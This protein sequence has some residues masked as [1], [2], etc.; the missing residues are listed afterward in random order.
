[1]KRSKLVR[2]RIV[3]RIKKQC[4][5]EPIYHI[6]TEEEYLQKLREKL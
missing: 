2:D 1:M 4:G 5:S 6:A 3:E